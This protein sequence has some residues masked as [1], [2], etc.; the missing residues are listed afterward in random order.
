[1]GSGD[2]LTRFFLGFFGTLA[3]A[4][5]IAGWATAGATRGQVLGT[6]VERYPEFSRI[7]SDL[8]GKPVEVRCRPLGRKLY[9]LAD[10]GGRTIDLAPAA[11]RDLVAL[12]YERARPTDPARVRLLATAVVTLAHEP[13]H[14]KGIADEAV[15]ECNAIRAAYGT[16]RAL[17]VGVGYARLLVRAYWAHYGELPAAYRSPVCNGAT[18]GLLAP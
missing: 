7:A 16:A 2:F 4:I 10:I 1:V 9:G 8:A 6:A 17:G 11:C 3:A 5:V 15:A 14:S 18:L 13:Q 12:A